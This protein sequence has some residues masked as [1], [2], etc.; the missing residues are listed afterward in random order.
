MNDIL[1]TATIVT[2]KENADVLKNAINSFLNTPLNVRLYIVDNSP[3]DELRSLCENIDRVEYIFNNANIGFGA[4]HNIIMRQL[5]KLGVYHLVLN[6]DISFGNGIIEALVD[7][8][9]QN[10][11]VGIVMPK[12]LYPDGSLQYL[13]KLL[14]TP[15]NWIARSFIPIS[16]IRRKIDYNFEMHFTDYNTVVEVPYLSGCFLFMPRHVIEEVGVFDEG[17]FMY[18]EDTD[19]CRRIGKKY[20]SMYYP[21]V[22]VFHHFRKGSHKNLRLFKIHVKAAIYYFNKW[23]W[24]VD[25]DRRRINRRIKKLYQ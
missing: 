2:Y 17:I 21:V 6:P 9:Q 3:T 5:D 14:P 1:V 16:A 20:K 24:F 23:G 13:C 25:P 11:E 15:L 8:L 12:V 10:Q 22:S 18:G 7:Y 19:L 4:A